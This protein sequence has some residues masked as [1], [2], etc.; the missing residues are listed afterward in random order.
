MTPMNTAIEI[1]KGL[2]FHAPIA[3]GNP[4]WEVTGKAGRGVWRAK[5][6]GEDY[7]GEVRAFTEAQIRHSVGM[8]RA[9]ART[10][11]E[12]WYAS[13]PLGRIVHYHNS[14]G[15]YVRCEVVMGTTVHNKASHKCLKPIALV[16]A[17][18]KGDLPRRMNDGSIYLGY[19]ADQIAKGEC[20]EPHFGCIYETGRQGG[21]HF[22]E[23][24]RTMPALDL[25][26][27]ELSA[28][29]TAK[30][31]LWKA[32]QAAQAALTSEDDYNRGPRERLEAALK[33]I[34]GAL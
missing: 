8:A 21:H 27:P 32:V 26:V 29:E 15:K 22:G 25:S 11:D 13:Q 17:W 2:K 19:H 9:F 34:Q 7:C 31:N 10:H 23:D 16:G 18:G 14:F 30:A 6:L 5:C 33:V 20:F 4:E 12:D 3:D 24:P 28:E 1:K